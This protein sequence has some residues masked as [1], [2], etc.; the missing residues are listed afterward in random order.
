MPRVERLIVAPVLIAAFVFAPATARAWVPIH[1]CGSG[2]YAYWAADTRP[3]NY[4]INSSGAPVSEGAVVSSIETCF[5]H[6]YAPCCSGASSR[7][8]GT[9]SAAATNNGDGV[10]T[11][12]FA[13]SRWPGELGDP[14]STLGVTIP[15]IWSD[16]RISEADILFNETVHD[17]CYSG[18]GGYDT[19]FEPVATHEIGHL[20]GLGHTE[21]SSAIMYYTYL[22]GTSGALR[23]D[24]ING[25]CTIYPDD[26]C[27]CTGPGDCEPPLECVDGECVAVDLCA[28]VVCGANE[29]CVAGRCV[30]LGDCPICRPCEDSGP[31]GANGQCIDRGD[32]QGRCIQFCNADGSCP[33]SSLCFPATAD[34]VEVHVC[35]NPDVAEVDAICPDHYVCSDCTGQGCPEGQQCFDGGCRPW[36]TDAICWRTDDQ[37][38]GC[39]EGSEG[40]VE[41]PE[42]QVVCTARCISNEDCGPCGACAETQDPFISLCVNNDAETAGFCPDG[43]VCNPTTPDG[44]VDADVDGDGDVDADG[45]GGG[46]GATGRCECRAPGRS[47]GGHSVAFAFLFVLFLVLGRFYRPGR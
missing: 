16:C 18:C 44:D 21:D 47:P 31:C 37:C 15:L 26:R 6:W 25:I 33:G 5:A 22:G 32:G 42:G 12:G 11:I 2:V 23:D 41:L 8:A 38:N 29:T 4:R 3:V 14:Y 34:G 39:P 40:C 28:D 9:T 27:G 45:D 10:T 35:L 19:A 17:F 30:N 24:D 1:N 36:P 20:F 43:W 7:H 13:S 46:E